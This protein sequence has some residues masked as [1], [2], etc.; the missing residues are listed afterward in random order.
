[1]NEMDLLARTRSGRSAP[2]FTKTIIRN[3]H[4]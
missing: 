3:G 2:P 1:M 4:G